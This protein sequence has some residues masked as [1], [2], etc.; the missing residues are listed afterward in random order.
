MEF[1]FTS[2]A[3]DETLRA[4]RMLG[5]ALRPGSVVGLVGDLGAGKTCFVK[6]LAAGACG[7]DENDVTSPTFT[8]MFE[9][10]G[11]V[12]VYHFDAYRLR[13]SADLEAAG[14]YDCLERGGVTVV[15]WA[16]RVT[17]AFP[18]ETLRISIEATGEHERRFAVFAQGEDHEYAAAYLQ[19]SLT[20]AFS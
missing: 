16:D 3:Y 1:T 2:T 7:V 19:Q 6:G 17:D 12:P 18:E 13:D 9:Y 5:R 15:E 11:T 14:F 10:P 4:G 20:G 8:I